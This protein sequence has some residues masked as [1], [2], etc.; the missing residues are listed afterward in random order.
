MKK[1]M[2]ISILGTALSLSLSGLARAEPVVGETP[3]NSLAGTSLTFASWGGILQEGQIAALGHFTEQ[4]GV[5]L[6]S[7][8]AYE[9]SKLKAQVEAGTLNWDVVHTSEYDPYAHCGT[10]V[11][12]L[13][14]SIIDTSKLPGG[15]YTECGVPALLYGIVLMYNTE[16]YGDNPPAS[17]KDFFDVEKFPGTRA[18]QGS[19]S[20][21]GSLIEASLLAQGGEQAT[22]LTEDVT[23]VIDKAL[24]P[25]RDN[26]ESFIFW[27]TGAEQ[28][29]MMESGEADMIMAWTGRAMNAVKNGAPYQPAWNQWL[30]VEDYLA[31]PKGAKN[32]AASNALINAYLGAE[33]QAIFAEMTS[34]S[35]VNVDSKPALEPEV[36]AFQISTPERIAQSYRHDVKYWVSHYD[37]L[38]AKWSEFVAGY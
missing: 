7:D 24:Q 18:I 21:S 14:L 33:A 23:A 38:L 11:Q 5:E 32:P 4:S 30:V 31:V 20:P 27:T 37:V 12:P 2:K 34:Y 9:M 8:P 22:M 19:S 1:Y 25:I 35:P 6:L 16:K 10:L 28:Q 29:N 13:D 3:E 26:S 36:A 15:H 17:W